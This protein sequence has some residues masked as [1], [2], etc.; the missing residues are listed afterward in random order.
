MKFMTF[1][2][3]LLLTIG[4]T[5]IVVNPNISLFYGEEVYDVEDDLGDLFWG[6]KEK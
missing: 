6:I 5:I 2:L 4:A 1:A 3:S